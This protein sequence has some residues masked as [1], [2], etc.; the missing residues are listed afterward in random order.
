MRSSDTA[1]EPLIHR[2]RWSHPLMSFPVQHLLFG[3]LGCSLACADPPEP[4]RLAILNEA[5]KVVTK[6]RSPLVC[7]H[8][9]LSLMLYFDTQI[10]WLLLHVF[11]FLFD[12]FRITLT[13]LRSG[14]NLHADI[15]RCVKHNGKQCCYTIIQAAQ[16]EYFRNL[17]VCFEH[18]SFRWI[19]FQNEVFNCTSQ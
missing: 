18:P 6:V 3:S 4:E 14:W 15:L 13:A 12:F 17:W 10:F 9:S 7:I 11:L 19:F 8:R 16:I 5:W 2:I 1:S